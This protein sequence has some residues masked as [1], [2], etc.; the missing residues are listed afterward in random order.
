M[1][2]LHTFSADLADLLRDRPDRSTPAGERADW[3]DRK[4]DLLERVAATTPEAVEL[5]VTARDVAVWL[6]AGGPE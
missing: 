6:R 2:D 3:F 4:A 5:A 1:T